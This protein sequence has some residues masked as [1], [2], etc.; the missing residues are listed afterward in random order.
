MF[1]SFKRLNKVTLYIYI[2]GITILRQHV[3]TSMYY[4]THQ[5]C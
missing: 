4:S 3:I 1:W 5:K 2:T